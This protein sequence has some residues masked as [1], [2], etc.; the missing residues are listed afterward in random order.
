MNS[1][2]GMTQPE[3]LRWLAD[4]WDDDIECKYTA[5]PKDKWE[6]FKLEFHGFN[7]NWEYRIKS[8]KPRINTVFGV[9]AA[10]DNSYQAIELTDEVLIALDKAGIDYEHNQNP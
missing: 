3:K 9:L 2:K 8:N 4:H 10:G 5:W 7:A 1:T 6:L